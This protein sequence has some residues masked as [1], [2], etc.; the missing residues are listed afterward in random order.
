MH[1]LNKCRMYLTVITVVDITNPN[2]THI[3]KWD[4]NNT[5]KRTSHLQWPNSTASTSHSW[6]LW[7]SSLQRSIIVH[8]TLVQYPLGRRNH[9]YHHW[10][11]PSTHHIVQFYQHQTPKLY[12]QYA[13]PYASILYKCHRRTHPPP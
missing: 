13:Q 6:A 10:Y 8:G 12:V 5:R 3:S 1:I 9:H 7:K 4:I 11:T 2:S